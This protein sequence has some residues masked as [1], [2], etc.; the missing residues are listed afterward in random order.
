MNKFATLTLLAGALA[1]PT[2]QAAFEARVGFGAPINSNGPWSYDVGEVRINPNADFAAV[3]PAGAYSAAAL[4]GYTGD[5]FPSFCLEL[6]EGFSPGNN[7]NV[8]LSTGAIQGGV[9]GGNPDK[10]SLG[11]AWLYKQFAAGTLATYDYDDVVGGQTVYDTGVNADPTLVGRK[12]AAGLL[13]E[14]IWYLEGEVSGFTLLDGD[15][16]GTN[17]FVTLAMNA[18]P[19]T[20]L[21]DANGAYGVMVMNMTN[22]SGR[23]RQDFL[24]V[25][26]EPSTYLAGALL[27]LPF[28]VGAIR[29]ARRTA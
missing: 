20:Y 3:I 14:A 28:V 16:A 11:T 19:A 5:N 25:V 10:I 27:G 18:L 4:N 8:S 13:Q 23:D 21:N 17:P 2:V 9:S 1:A 15:D 7:Y 6:N 22:T 29:R 12:G 24:V 26:P